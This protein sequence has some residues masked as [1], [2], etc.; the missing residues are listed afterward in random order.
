[1]DLE[2]LVI[3]TQ[4]FVLFFVFNSSPR[5]TRYH[6]AMCMPS[7]ARQ[8]MCDVRDVTS[9]RQRAHA[10][11]HHVARFLPNRLLAQLLGSA[12]YLAAMQL[13]ASAA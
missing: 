10:M 13:A 2:R 7:R 1:M 11:S 9:F 6:H 3:I 4:K 8:V 5:H 12:R